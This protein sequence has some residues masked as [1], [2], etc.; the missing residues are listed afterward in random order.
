MPFDAP[1]LPFGH[2]M[3]AE[4]GQ[5]AGGRPAFL[6]GGRSE[7]WPHQLH[8]REAQFV[9]RQIDTRGIGWIHGSHATP[10]ITMQRVGSGN[11]WTHNGGASV[12][13]AGA[14][15]SS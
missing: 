11:S 1:P 5:E 6:I 10:P 15:I 3:L 13:K 12:S 7:C 4:S 2:F 9:Q 14:V 8:R